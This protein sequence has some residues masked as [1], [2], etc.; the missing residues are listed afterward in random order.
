MIFSSLSGESISLIAYC[1]STSIHFVSEKVQLIVYFVSMTFRFSN[2]LLVFLNKCI[3]HESTITLII[4]KKLT[5]LITHQLQH[6][7][8]DCPCNCITICAHN[9][10]KLK[11]VSITTLAFFQKSNREMPLTFLGHYATRPDY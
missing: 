10:P 5:L 9:Q 2:L 7:A 4:K 8:L 3:Y 6:L 11:I 1:I